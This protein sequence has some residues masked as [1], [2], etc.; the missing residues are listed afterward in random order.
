MSV[1]KPNR[2]L[3]QVV[4]DLAAVI[5]QLAT[6]TAPEDDRSRARL[7]KIISG[8]AAFLADGASK[9]DPILKPLSVFDPADPETAAHVVALTTVAQ[10]RHKLA[11]LRPFYGSGVYALYYCGDFEPYAL[12][13]RTEQP[14]Y[15]GKADPENPNADDPTGQGLKLFGRL[16]DHARTI[17]SAD[18]TLDLGDFECRFLVVQSGFQ[19]AAEARLIHFFKPIWN[20]ET[21]I[22][23][24]IGKHGD[25]ATTRANKRSPWDTLH[26]G[27]GWAAASAQDQQDRQKV[28]KDIADHLAKYPPKASVEEVLDFFMGEFR[29]IQPSEFLDASGQTQDVETLGENANIADQGGLG[30][31]SIEF[32]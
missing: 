2:P 12:L 31:Q 30:Q 22:C 1:D 29:Q 13:A 28:I 3:R 25:S 4:S 8:Q 15:V 5:K 6:A 21:K 23:F 16:K 19:Q 26:P 24:G 11:S 9:L 14:V 18:S 27:R 10:P 7:A 17:R 20:K 32:E